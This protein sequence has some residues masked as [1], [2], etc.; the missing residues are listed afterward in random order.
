MKVV[1]C[2]INSFPQKTFSLS[3]VRL[4]FF[5]LGHTRRGKDERANDF[6][7]ASLARTLC[8]QMPSGPGSLRVT[9]GFGR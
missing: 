5:F 2:L 4:I 7:V 9:A 3:K 8:L 1:T 6:L